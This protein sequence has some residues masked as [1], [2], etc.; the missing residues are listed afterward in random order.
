MLVAHLKLGHDKV[1]AQFAGGFILGLAIRGE[2]ERADDRQEDAASTGSG[3]RHGRSKERLTKRKPIRQS[4]C[5][6]PEPLNKVSRN[7]V[8]KTRFHKPSSEEERDHDQP[9]HIIRECAEGRGEREGFGEH[10]SGQSQKRP[11]ADR[12]GG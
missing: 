11:R 3:A 7:T 12:Q 10:G 6:L 2:G 9:N 8:T 1:R 4:Q 5:A